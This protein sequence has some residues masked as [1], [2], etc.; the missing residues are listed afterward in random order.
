[1]MDTGL[2]PSSGRNNFHSFY[3]NEELF[4]FFFWEE[5]EMWSSDFTLAKP[6]L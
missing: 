5:T 1:M 6:D 4:Y 2:T 3:L